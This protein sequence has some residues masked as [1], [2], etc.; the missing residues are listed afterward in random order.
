MIET[1]PV[2][3]VTTGSNGSASGSA[4]SDPINGILRA[5]KVDYH[6]S[7]P[8]ATTDLTITELSAMGRTLLTKTDTATD[9]IVYPTVEADDAA[10]AAITDTVWP[11]CIDGRVR[12]SV[13]QCNALN[14][15]VTVYLQVER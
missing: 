3:V 6:A 13:A 4:D 11:I 5:I 8:G 2:K 7:A 1:Y 14:P 12:V 10:F 15:A 9:D